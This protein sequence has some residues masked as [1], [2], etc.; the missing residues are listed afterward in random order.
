MRLVLVVAACLW[1][2]LLG[3]ALGSRIGGHTPAL[4]TFVYLS[5]ARLCHQRPER[6]LATNGVQWPVC[7]RCSGLYLAAPLGALAAW[8]MGRD[9]ST[10]AWRA[11]LIGASVPTAVTLALEWTSLAP[12]DNAARLIAALPLGATVA[13]VIVSVAPDRRRQSDTLTG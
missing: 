2:G 13:F 5:M 4:T 11:A 3:A 7:A 10:R 9:R 1:L 12:V 6:S 8:W